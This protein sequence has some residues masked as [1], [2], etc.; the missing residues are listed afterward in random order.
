LNYVYDVVNYRAGSNL[1]AFFHPASF[2]PW[3]DA[4]L[5]K[6]ACLGGFSA[7]EV[8]FPELA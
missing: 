3:A 6:T 4:F 2:P 7:L 1:S 5:R 8:H